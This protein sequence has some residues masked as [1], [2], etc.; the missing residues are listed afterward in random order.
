ML[1]TLP[2]DKNNKQ[3]RVGDVVTII[4]KSGRPELGV[5][6]K[7]TDEFVVT[8]CPLFG[9]V[10]KRHYRNVEITQGSWWEDK[11]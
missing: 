2:L 8:E 10:S 3:I 1:P 9:D 5:V 7:M 4:G 6:I 11:V